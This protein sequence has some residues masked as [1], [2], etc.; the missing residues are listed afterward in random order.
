M[1]FKYGFFVKLSILAI[2]ILGGS[3]INTVY[4][5]ASDWLEVDEQ[6]K[7]W[8]KQPPIITSK[9]LFPDTYLKAKSIRADFCERKIS[10]LDNLQ[11]RIVALLSDL[12]RLF[13]STNSHL[14][15]QK[16]EIDMMK[17][18]KGL[19]QF[20]VLTDPV[21]A[22]SLD[23]E[24]PL[25]ITDA[26]LEECNIAAKK[27]DNSSNCQSALIEFRELYNFAQGTLSQ[28]LAFKLFRH[29]ENLEKQ[30]NNFYERSRSQTIW[31]TAIN[32][33]LFHKKNKEHKYLSPPNSQ[34]IVMH[35]NLVIEN[36]G[37][38]VDGEQTKEAIMLEAIG[39]NWWKQD[40]WYI[41]SGAS[42][43]ALYS[44]RVGS[45]DWGY[46]LAFHF[47]S[48]FTLGI[49][50]HDG[51]TGFFISIDLLKFIQDK[52]SLIKQYRGN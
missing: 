46:G 13:Q 19:A 21:L 1:M 39:I 36:V 18:G 8:C 27:I 25:R 30:W 47:E 49:A 33:A 26:S 23:S 24:I 38:A 16:T 41:P 50:E 20:E 3:L 4:A 5:Q 35:P 45:E 28:P 6:F 48:K 31:E 42:A 7:R 2:T 34:V 37:D 52:N 51:E 14:N 10:T 9:K 17:S 15:L 44:D 11:S 40:K 22:I 43:I 32:G 12:N 29:L